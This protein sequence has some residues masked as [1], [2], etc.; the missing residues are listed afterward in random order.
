MKGAEGGILRGLL[1]ECVELELLRQENAVSQ[2][3][4]P[5]GGKTPRG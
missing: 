5:R 4:G 2:I 3:W 1:P